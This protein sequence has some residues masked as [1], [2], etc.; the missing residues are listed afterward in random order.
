MNLLKTLHKKELL[1]QGETEGALLSDS[2]KKHLPRFLKGKQE[3]SICRGGD[4]PNPAQ[5]GS[6]STAQMKK[7]GTWLETTLCQ[8][9]FFICK[10]RYKEW[11]GWGC[12]S[13]HPSTM[14]N[15]KKQ[16]EN[17]QATELFHVLGAPGLQGL[18]AQRKGKWVHSS[19]HHKAL[20]RQP[21]PFPASTP[22]V[23]RTQGLKVCFQ[24]K[25][26]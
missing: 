15:V 6:L 20:S 7:A 9:Q 10:P 14:P 25:L 16:C 8:K 13:P 5:V 18:V 11:G 17:Q 21:Q 3:S 22:H 2:S 26:G 23:V 4:E 19:A 12:I 1:S 24:A